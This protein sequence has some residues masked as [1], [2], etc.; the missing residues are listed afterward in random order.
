MD[1]PDFVSPF[2]NALNDNLELIHVAGHFGWLMRLSD[3]LPDWMLGASMQPLL[4]FQQV[5]STF[6]C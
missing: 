2:T 4:V 6:E 5:G 3:Y 1:F